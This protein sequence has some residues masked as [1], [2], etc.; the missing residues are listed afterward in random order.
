MLEIKEN[1]SMKNLGWGNRDYEGHFFLL[2]I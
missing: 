1:Q 2:E